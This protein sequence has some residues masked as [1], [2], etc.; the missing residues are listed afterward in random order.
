MTANMAGLEGDLPWLERERGGERSWTDARAGGAGTLSRASSGP[1]DRPDDFEALKAA[2]LQGVKPRHRDHVVVLP[3]VAEVRLWQD[4]SSRR[5]EAGGF[6]SCC[7][8]L[9][10]CAVTAGRERESAGCETYGPA[11]KSEWPC[12][13][14]ACLLLQRPPR[15]ACRTTPLKAPC[16]SIP[17]HHLQRDLLERVMGGGDEN[18]SLLHRMAQRLER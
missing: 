1:L 8:C 10:C 16:I 7:T 2:A 15:P 12:I 18:E 3:P 6:S 17:T 13:V 14:R 11:V 5:R 9:S 4:D